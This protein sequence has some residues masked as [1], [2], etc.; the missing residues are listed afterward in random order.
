M[1]TTDI[2]QHLIEELEQ[3]TKRLNGGRKDASGM[4]AEGFEFPI[5]APPA[6]FKGSLPD[7][8]GA[9]SIQKFAAAG[10]LFD[11]HADA[12]GFLKG[13]W[14]SARNFWYSDGG[15]KPWA[16]YEEYDNYLDDYGMDA[17]LVAYHS[18]H[19]GMANDGNFVAPLGAPWGGT[20]DVWSFNMRLG[21]E[22]MRYVF[23]S[24]CF[25]CRVFEGH[26]PIRSWNPA[27][28]GWRMLFG[29]ETTSVDAPNYGSAFWKHWNAGKSFSTAWLDASWY[30]IS[31]N[32]A[33]SACA[34]GASA[35]EAKDRLYNE[36]I[37]QWAAASRSYW[38]WRWYYA[39]AGANT[40]RATTLRLPRTIVSAVLEPGRMSES[41]A[42]EVLARHD[43]PLTAGLSQ[44]A[45][46]GPSRAF[47]ASQGD[48]RVAFEADGSYDID[49]ARPN[50]EAR[51]QLPVRDA[52][53]VAQGVVRGHG[54]DASPLILDRVLHKYDAG[55]TEQ[56][57]GTFEEP[58]VVET[59]VQ[60]T[61]QING[62]P[63]LL[64]GQ[65]GVSVSVDNDGRVTSIRN[66]TRA[67]ADISDRPMVAAAGPPDPTGTASA[68]SRSS[69]SAP[70]ERLLADAFQE[71][72]KD[73][74][75]RGRMPVA[76][77]DVPGTAE[78]GYAIRDDEA[79]LVARKEVE[80][81]LGG[82]FLKRYVVE[83]PIREY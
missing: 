66:T 38:H 10:D 12:D 48:V 57:D 32:Q 23:W 20:S 70:P 8:V 71:R 17:V 39:A 46:G 33:P 81:D 11:T 40:R 18:G 26:N 30:D 55:G 22:R 68:V 69:A 47:R 4:Q 41:R 53:S 27:N 76:Y 59:T 37:F 43:V 21:N 63:V 28:L 45:T 5:A 82:G 56:G 67:I 9:F 19:G 54:L 6:G 1:S 42:F 73:W 35:A 79:V 65:G 78:V 31:H 14:G 77:S 74:I 60:F 50:L 29:Y 36:R 75:V 15:V 34:V 44:V 7:V 62:L 72:L 83:A 25:S 61:Q 58:R 51:A 16:Y 24:T 3:A 64:P 49:L 52:L 13:P 2:P 80:V